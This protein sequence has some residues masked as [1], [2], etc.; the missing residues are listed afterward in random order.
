MV[1]A[2]DGG[3][4]VTLTRS[5]DDRFSERI[6]LRPGET[7]LK[8]GRAPECH[9]N[10]T[11]PG[12]S[13]FHAEIRACPEGKGVSVRDVS[14]NGTGLQ[15]LGGKKT[16]LTKG[17][18]TALPDGAM[19]VVPMNTKK[20]SGEDKPDASRIWVTVR[21]GEGEEDT[22]CLPPDATVLLQTA[23]AALNS[24]HVVTGKAGFE[25]APEQATNVLLAQPRE[26]EQKMKIHAAKTSSKSGHAMTVKESNSN[27]VSPPQAA[28]DK[29]PLGVEALPA[30]APHARAKGRARKRAASSSPVP[31]VGEAGPALSSDTPVSPTESLKTKSSPDKTAARDKGAEGKRG[32]SSSSSS[33][34]SSRHRRRA[35]SSHSS[36]RA[37]KRKSGAGRRSKQRKARR[38]SSRSRSRHRRRRSRSR[39]HRKK[40]SGRRRKPEKEGGP[41][42]EPPMMPWPAPGA[43]WPWPGGMAAGMPPWAHWGGA[44][45]FPSAGPALG[46]APPPHLD[47][48]RQQIFFMYQRFNPT[49]LPQ[50]DSILEKYKGIEHKLLEAL[51][52]KYLGA[53]AAAPQV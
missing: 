22:P 51:N 30:S 19:L 17:Q 31:A 10:V 15:V 52:A 25:P 47:P 44:M 24:E 34:S 39:S 26:S 13:V 42:A 38:R 8:I 33:P 41:G 27:L 12:V 6:W 48:M 29:D 3:V 46:Q 45:G 18:D 21:I 53:D 35:R 28:V 36:A 23:R 20:R 50:L 2:D 11:L 32:R 16:A 40:E 5:D 1:R 49:K 4:C 14:T 37:P 7:V 9:V 43:Q